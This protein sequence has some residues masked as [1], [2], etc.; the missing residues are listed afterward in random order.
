MA[1]CI[2]VA[3]LHKVG[4]FVWICRTSCCICG[5]SVPGYTWQIWQRWWHSG[6]LYY[7]PLHLKT[8][9]HLQISVVSFS[10]SS[11]PLIDVSNF[12]H[13]VEFSGALRRIQYSICW[14]RIKWVLW[15]IW[16]GKRSSL[17]SLK[18]IYFVYMVPELVHVLLILH[19]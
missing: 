18:I 1:N 12:L 17:I 2:G 10:S 9:A 14:H 3:A 16:Q 15:S 6:L 4:V 7:I 19:I 13:M 8:Q 5:H 11:P